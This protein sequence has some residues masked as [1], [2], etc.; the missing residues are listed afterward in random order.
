MRIEGSNFSECKIWTAW[1]SAGTIIVKS[2]QCQMGGHLQDSGHGATGARSLPS[3][4]SVGCPRAILV[5]PLLFRISQ[6]DSEGV[7]SLHSSPISGQSF[8]EPQQDHM[9]RVAHWGSGQ[10]ILLHGPVC[11]QGPHQ[12]QPPCSG[13]LPAAFPRGEKGELSQAA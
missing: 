5:A 8:S 2:Q 9:S 6:M 1:N 7:W 10:A 4:A 3:E 12:S 13:S 11:T